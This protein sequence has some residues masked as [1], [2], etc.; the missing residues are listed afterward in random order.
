MPWDEFFADDAYPDDD[1]KND[2]WADAALDA[3]EQLRDEMIETGEYQR[4]RASGMSLSEFRRCEL[5]AEAV[6]GGGQSPRSG[7]ERT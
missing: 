5:E 1:P 6:L 2:G 4:W 7:G 3:A